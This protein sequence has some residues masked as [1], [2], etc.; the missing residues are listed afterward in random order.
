MIKAAIAFTAGVVATLVAT[1]LLDMRMQE[2]PSLAGDAGL[3]ESL[4]ELAD[5]VREAG[6]F[7]RGHLWYGSE[8]EQAEAHRH[9]VRQLAGALLSRGLVDPDFPYFHEIDTRT[10]GGMDNADQRYLEALLD[11][12]AVYR[13]WGTRGSSRRLDFTLYGED[14]LAPSISTVA[15]DRLV[16]EESG[17]FEL[18]VGGEER[19]HNWLASRPGRVRLLIRQ[20]FSDWRNEAP[21]EIHIDR[22]D[23]ERPPYP[24][25]TRARMAGRIQ[26][27]TRHFA[28]SVRRWPEYSRTRFHKL[29]P[30]NRLT[31]PRDTGDTGGL[32][33]RLMVGGHFELADDQALIVTTWPSGA[34]YQGIQLGHHWWESLDYANRQSSLTTEQARRS[35]DGAYHF[36]IAARDPGFFNWLDTEGFPRGVILLR[37]DGM[38]VAELPEAEHPKAVLVKYDE[39]ASRLPE[40]E[41]RISAAE[42]AAAIALRRRHVQRRFDH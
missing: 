24:A 14:P 31:E 4:E 37:Y 6:V 32:S 8:R 35:S 25:L 26:D 23:A 30:A 42:R 12:D 5:A 36:V 40:D 27:A 18:F 33:G 41:P 9:V 2:A 15:T 38:S 21:G 39:I 1:F 22:V 20:I 7:V 28:D 10:K 16:V 29:L 13:V 11:G 34:A 17:S 19:P 3:E